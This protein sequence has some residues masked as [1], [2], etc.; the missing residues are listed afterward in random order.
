MPPTPN[1]GSVVRTPAQLRALAS[2]ARQEIVDALARLGTMS[3]AQ[4]A[5]TL[6]RPADGLYY[7]IRALVRAGLNVAAGRRPDRGRS[8]ALYR[9]V[10]PDLRI[11]PALS[12]SGPVVDIVASLLRLGIRD[13]RRASK[14]SDVARSSAVRDLW[15]LRSVGRLDEHQLKR[16]NALVRRLLHEVGR[17]RQTGRLFAVTFLLTPI[18]RA[19]RS[20]EVRT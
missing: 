7:H 11:P 15:A 13:Y 14:R 19:R 17:P 12:K 9:A 16:V 6:D 1:R 20:R 10:A 4:I 2:P 8:E 5:D 3:I 18:D